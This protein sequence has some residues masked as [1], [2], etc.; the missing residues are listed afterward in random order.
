[1]P[2]NRKTFLAQSAALAAGTFLGSRSYA[3]PVSM[4]NATDLAAPE[5]PEDLYQ[6]SLSQWSYHRAIFGD[7]RDDY[8]WWLKMIHSNPDAVLKGPL[9]PRDIVVKAREFDVSVV[10]LVNVLWFGHGN[11][12]AWLSEFKKRANGEGVSFGVLMCD[13]LGHVGASD[14]K[15]RK[16]AVR[17]HIHWLDTAAELGCLYFRVNAYGDGSYLQQCRQ[18]AESLHELAEAAMQYDIEVLVENHGHPGSNGAWLAMLLEM[19]E[20]PR[21]GAFTDFDNFFMGGW[22]LVPERRYDTLQG[23]LDLAPYTRAVS[24]KSYDFD[25]D[26]NETKVDF[27]LCLRTALDGGFRSL[28]SAEYE[29]EHLGEH[30]GS[31]LTVELL[32]RLRVKLFEEMKA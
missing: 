31:R 28:A 13:Q 32:R 19:A 15:E 16:S 8:A 12:A 10:D 3:K 21:V 26:G 24:A 14:A 11:D 7:S 17:N 27:E 1:M 2:I 30:E 29:G 4:L 25:A 20:H 5:K 23:M 22:G 9:D 6:I 18:S